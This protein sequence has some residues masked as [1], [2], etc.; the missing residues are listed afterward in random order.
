[1][2]RNR[3]Y[4]KKNKIV[5]ESYEEYL[6]KLNFIDKLKKDDW[7]KK[8]TLENKYPEQV[9]YRNNDENI[10]I[11]YTMKYLKNINNIKEFHIITFSNDLNL[12][13]IRSLGS[14]HIE[15]LENLKKITLNIIEKNFELD[16]SDIKIQ[17]HYVPSTYYFH[18]HF[19]NKEIEDSKNSIHNIYDLD[20]VI[21]NLEENT[22]YYKKNI[23]IKIKN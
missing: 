10:I 4:I 9:I 15:L 22:D 7:I 23:L 19:M 18:I 1:M 13:T 14:E 12:R 21:K 16:I 17:I 20:Q 5:N 2:N 3:F 11:L 6:L 8:I